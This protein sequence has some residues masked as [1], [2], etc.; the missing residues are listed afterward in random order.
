MHDIKSLAGVGGAEARS[1]A[2]L[3]VR[4]ARSGSLVSMAAEL[5]AVST[6]PDAARG[7]LVRAWADRLERGV[8]VPVVARTV[9]QLAAVVGRGLSGD[10][11]AGARQAALLA[12]AGRWHDELDRGRLEA[13]V[14]AELAAGRVPDPAV[15]ATFRRTALAAVRTEGVERVLGLLTEPVLNVGEAWADRA[16]ADLRWHGLLAHA[17]SAKA[18][19]PTGVWNGAARTLIAAQGAEETR[20]AV[21]SWLCLVG[22]PRTLP[23]DGAGGGRADPWDPYNTDALRGLAWTLALLPPDP[24]TADA[25]AALAEAAMAARPPQPRVARAAGAG[26]RARQ[27]ARTVPQKL[28][29]R[30]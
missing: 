24:S 12:T 11:L 20:A 17:R 9:L 26:V 29:E 8:D 3:L 27:P 1:Y 6:W 28:S 13:L 15:V 21:L 10:P 25:L 2:D 4:R 30:A 7:Q 22:S 14:E 23:V 18:T 5:E 19:R 16:M